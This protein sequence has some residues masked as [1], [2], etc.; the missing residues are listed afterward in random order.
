MSC[1]RGHPE[2]K[3]SVNTP[4]MTSTTTITTT[5]STDDDNDNLSIFSQPSPLTDR[6]SLSRMD[7]VKLNLGPGNKGSGVENGVRGK[8][9]FLHKYN[10]K[11]REKDCSVSYL[12]VS[13]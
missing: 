8:D 5:P 12:I 4:T 7:S 11:N 13:R 9:R 1:I 3:D 2:V 10:G 6:D